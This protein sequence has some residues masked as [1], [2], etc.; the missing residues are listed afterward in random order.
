MNEVIQPK[1]AYR[2][3][4]THKVNKKS[5]EADLL[6]TEEFEREMAPI[7]VMGSMPEWPPKTA[8]FIWGYWMEEV[9][10]ERA[11]QWMGRPYASAINIIKLKE[12][13]E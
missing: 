7:Y 8:R 1:F 11:Q 13:K 12:G 4:F 9:D 2:V 3:E 10:W 5:I 6:E